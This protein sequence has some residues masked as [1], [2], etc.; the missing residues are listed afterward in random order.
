MTDP[1]SVPFRQAEIDLDQLADN[2][3][4]LR[5]GVGSHSVFVDVGA[6]AWGHGLD[7][8]VPALAALG[9]SGLVVARSVEAERVRA[10]APDT[11]IIT[12][13][14]AA[15]ESFADAAALG[16]APLL[17]SRAE[18]ERCLTADVKAVV[19][20]EDTGSGLPGFRSDELAAA[21]GD[22]EAGGLSVHALSALAI[23]GAELFGVS[24]EAE[25]LLHGLSPVLRLWAPVAATKRVRKDVG[26][27]YGY[28]YRTATDSTLALVTLGYADGLSRAGGN[29][30]PVGLEGTTRPAAGRLAMDALMLDLG[31]L[32]APVLGAEATILGDA[33]RG[34]PTAADHARALGMHSAE[35]TTRL[36]ARPLRYARRRQS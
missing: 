13:Q 27:S 18:L 19:L 5:R 32:P 23:L 8:V 2:L 14:H 25:G 20:A 29:R 21:R 17:R 3:S 15:D 1:V 16:V 26:V 30:M 31:D 28:T 10:L 7:I 6:N 22:A 34:E 24:E 9:V 4:R 11:L 35:V 12:T 36:T 33:R